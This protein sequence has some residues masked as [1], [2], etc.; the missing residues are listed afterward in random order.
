M[1]LGMRL[2]INIRRA[3]S[4]FRSRESTAISI[5][6]NRKLDNVITPTFVLSG[7]GIGHL[8]INSFRNWY[9]GMLGVMPS[10]LLRANFGKSLLAKFFSDAMS[11][12]Q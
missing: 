1:F 12:I 6:V 2:Y 5:D 9:F 10:Q 3:L 4:S 8:R 7:T 11:S